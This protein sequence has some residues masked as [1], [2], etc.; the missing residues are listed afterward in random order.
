MNAS[1]A[2]YFRRR[3]SA[4]STRQALATVSAFTSLFT[5]GLMITGYAQ[6]SASISPA[7]TR[8]VRGYAI[9]TSSATWYPS[10]LSHVQRR[11]SQGGVL[12]RKNGESVRETIEKIAQIPMG[13]K[14][15]IRPTW[16]QMQSKQGRLEMFEH[17]QVT[18][19]MAA[20]YGKRVGKLK[21]A[22]SGRSSCSSSVPLGTS[23]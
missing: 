7:S 16:R 6:F 9:P 3:S 14:L 2:S 5:D 18:M 20:K 8:H 19:E 21:R 10:R 11:T 4:S 1:A 17:W 22:I 23:A 15:Y 13:S 12:K